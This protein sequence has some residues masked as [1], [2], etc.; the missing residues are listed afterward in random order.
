MKQATEKQHRGDGD[1]D[2]ARIRGNDE[3]GA[4]DARIR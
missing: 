1:G 4:I 3:E 2:S